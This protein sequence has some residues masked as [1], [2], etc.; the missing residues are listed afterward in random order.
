MRK[1][2]IVL[3]TCTQVRNVLPANFAQ[4]TNEFI[5]IKMKYSFLIYA[6]SW[7][8]FF[9]IAMLH[10]ALTHCLHLLASFEA[11]E[12]YKNYIKTIFYNIADE[13][14]SFPLKHIS[15]NFSFPGREA[16]LSMCHPGMSL[17]N[18]ALGIALVFVSLQRIHLIWYG[19][20]TM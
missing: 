7:L 12:H 8:N 5:V 4:I 17:G 19:I 11:A 9:H 6:F 10:I 15:F 16:K 14:F 20:S 3:Y 13:F 1:F 2:L 18:G